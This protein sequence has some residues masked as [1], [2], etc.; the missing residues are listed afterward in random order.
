MRESAQRN[1]TPQDSEEVHPSF[2]GLAVR[3]NELLE[4]CHKL[5]ERLSETTRKLVKDV[6]TTQRS[7]GSE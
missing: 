3:G 1:R 6:A 5:S 2:L 7:R 4:R